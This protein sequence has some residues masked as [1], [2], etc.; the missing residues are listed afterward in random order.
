LSPG[1]RTNRKNLRS[2]QRTILL[3][4]F[5]FSSQRKLRVCK[6]TC[7]QSSARR[8]QAGDQIWCNRSIA[9]AGKPYQTRVFAELVNGITRMGA[10]W[11][12]QIACENRALS[13]PDK[14]LRVRPD[15]AAVSFAPSGLTILPLTV[16]RLTPWAAFF[17]RFATALSP[18][19][20]HA[21]FDLPQTAFAEINLKDYPT[22]IF[23]SCRRLS[24]SSVPESSN[25]LVIAALPFS[26]AVMT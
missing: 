6:Y 10:V 5:Y 23:S 17:R 18:G 13:A 22:S 26:T 24:A 20:G 15:Q 21:F 1:R 16:P 19:T 8:S 9:F 4:S 14:G 11:V 3:Y 7:F 25:E 2:C 12:V